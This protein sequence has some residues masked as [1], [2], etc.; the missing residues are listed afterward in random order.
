MFV[1]D[2]V[3]SSRKIL[4][5]NICD[6]K[7][8][9][10]LLSTVIVSIMLAM[11]AFFEKFNER[12][13]ESPR[14]AHDGDFWGIVPWRADISLFFGVARVARSY[15]LS[16]SGR[17]VHGVNEQSWRG[18]QK[19]QY[20]TPPSH[21]RNNTVY[22][23]ARRGHLRGKRCGVHILIRATECQIGGERWTPLRAR[24]VI[25]LVKWRSKASK[26]NSQIFIAINYKG[27]LMLREFI[28]RFTNGID[29][30]V[31]WRS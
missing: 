22:R 31:A 6:S 25:M 2:H 21:K 4:F 14:N 18:Q 15:I 1:I 30:I 11:L 20:T 3:L 9:R 28:T 7:S 8:R 26:R 17:I 5:C 24:C 27:V 10:E 29:K 23:A 19:M 16:R 13:L 12:S